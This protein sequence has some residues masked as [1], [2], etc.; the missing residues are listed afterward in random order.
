MVRERDRATIEN[1]L[2]PLRAALVAAGREG[3]VDA[4]IELALSK[5]RARLTAEHVAAH[6]FHANTFKHE[7]DGVAMV[8]ATFPENISSGE[9]NRLERAK[10]LLKELVLRARPK[11]LEK[12]PMSSDDVAD[13][14][15]DE[16]DA[17]GAGGNAGGY[18]AV[19]SDDA[20]KQRRKIVAASGKGSKQ[21]SDLER[22]L[23]IS[24]HIPSLRALARENIIAPRMRSECA[25]AHAPP[26][27][28][29][30]T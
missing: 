5:E 14:E 7:I 9:R 4:V 29:R 2:K 20:D 6:N 10:F 23:Y 1:K 19:L 12:F 22:S 8:P 11:A 17:S 24:Q 28:L 16:D 18:Y 13:N 30:H 26:R 27:A 25:R 21:A 15:D 3:G